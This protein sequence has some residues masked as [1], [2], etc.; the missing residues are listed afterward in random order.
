MLAENIYVIAISLP[1]K[2]L[3]KLYRMIGKKVNLNVSPKTKK[4]KL[5]TN[6]I[7]LQ[8]LIKNCF[9]SKKVHLK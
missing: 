6:E 9:S 3:E 5:I 4:D 8:F 7:A 2:E 1:E